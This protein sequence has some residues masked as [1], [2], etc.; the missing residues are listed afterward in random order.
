MDVRLL[1]ALSI[2]ALILTA[3]SN[4]KKTEDVF[5]Q[6]SQGDGV[7]CSP[8]SLIKTKFIV[9]YEDGRMEVVHSENAD[10]FV[11]KFLK[12]NIQAIKYV[13]YDQLI[14][15]DDPSSFATENQMGAASDN[16]GSEKVHAEVAWNQGLYGAGVKVAVVDAAV[17]YSQPQLS[18]R[19]SVNTQEQSGSNGFDDDGNG[20]KDDVYGWDFYVNGPQP[21]TFVMPGPQEEPNWHGSHVAGII[22][23]D[24][25]TGSVKGMA[26]QAELIPVNFMDRQGGG[27]LS[28]AIEGI[29]Y[30]ASR[31]A[32]II[33]A[34]WGGQGCSES[35]RQ[36]ILTASTTGNGGKG[37]LF[38]SAAGN[39]G[40]DFDKVPSSYYTF[41]AVFNLANQLTIAATDSFDIMANFSNK[42]YNWVQFA[43]PG[44]GI[45]S[46]VPRFFSTSGTTSLSGTSMA[47]P[48]VSGAAALIWSAKPNAT[49]SQVKQALLKSTDFKSL[50]TVTQGRLNVDRALQEIRRIVP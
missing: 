9:N 47:T 34:S 14:K 33:N 24:H 48:F 22:L 39:D 15:L 17:D 8:Q 20:Y 36:A 43:A 27:N 50:K 26:P 6:Y 42:S 10:V 41:P 18:P 45:I 23:A 1:T 32:K 13:E 25:M 28:D 5:P 46:T 7:L 29:K 31:G 3:C 40:V 35:L 12:P 21:E 4:T 37:L 49:A 19:L 11:K 16:W 38:I 30:A 2:S 44:V